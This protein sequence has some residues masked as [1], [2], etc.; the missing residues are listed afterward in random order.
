[1]E[2]PYQGNVS[3]HNWPLRQ[4]NAR[5]C[6]HVIASCHVQNS[7]M[8]SAYVPL[9]KFRTH[10]Y[11]SMALRNSSTDVT[12]CTANGL[13]KLGNLYCFSRIEDSDK[14]LLLLLLLLL[15]ANIHVRLRMGKPAIR[16]DIFW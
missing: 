14:L 7:A 12:F 3:W 11:T 9:P 2:F 15:F 10:C 6:L 4:M 8:L 1:M 13:W 5:D 16:L